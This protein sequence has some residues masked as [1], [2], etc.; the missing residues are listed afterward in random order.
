M[1]LTLQ[2]VQLCDVCQ[3]RPLENMHPAVSGKC[4]RTG[5]LR[6]VTVAVVP[7]EHA[8]ALQ[9]S[10]SQA[11]LLHSH[12]EAL[13]L[14]V[15]TDMSSLIPAGQQSTGCMSLSAT[16]SRALPVPLLQQEQSVA[17]TPQ[18]A[19]LIHGKPS[20]AVIATASQSHDG[21]RQKPHAWLTILMQHQ[22]SDADPPTVRPSSSVSTATLNHVHSRPISRLLQGHPRSPVPC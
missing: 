7:G 21:T 6:M 1:Q 16:R 14:S 19:S 13:Q 8:G 15:S 22:Q 17:D 2:T 3:P 11:M 10:G 9:S 12:A 20:S 4:S 5:Q 18:Q